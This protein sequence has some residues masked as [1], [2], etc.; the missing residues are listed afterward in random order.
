[1]SRSIQMASSL[2][3]VTRLA[4]IV[5]GCIAL[6]ALVSGC[7]TTQDS[8]YF[9]YGVGTNLYSEDI[10]Q[11]TQLQDLYFTELCRQSLPVVSTKDIDCT[12]VRMSAPDWTL[13]VQAG[14]NDVDRRCDS[15]LAWLDD[16]R[17][18]NGAVLKEL[19]DVTVASQAIMRVAGVSANPITLAGLAFGLASDTFTNINS[20]LLTEIDKTTVQTLVLKR[21]D[22]FRLDIAG[23]PIPDRPTA[24]HALRLYLTICTPFAIETEINST[25]TVFQTAGVAG[26]ARTDP[27]VDPRTIAPLLI[28]DIR[29]PLPE[30]GFKPP[31]GKTAAQIL[32]ERLRDTLCMV[33]TGKTRDQSVKDFLV[34]RGLMLG[35]QSLANVKIPKEN[36]LLQHAAASIPDCKK[37]GFRNAYEVGRFGVTSENSKAQ[38][39]VNIDDLQDGLRSKLKL[40]DADLT[41][42]QLDGPTRTAI[43]SF[44]DKNNLVPGDQ[45]DDALITALNK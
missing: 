35:S 25:I 29:K 42:H 43:K 30:G 7:D 20:R 6:A 3:R 45:V 8:Q 11:T 44:R 36:D 28:G 40:P 23:R 14:M 31:P 1:M 13:I 4:R 9:R 33:D 37:A 34:G 24:A 18:T 22:G 41:S 21:R 10:V 2:G 12:G 32:D 17:R 38:V 15:Y 26:L 19:G 39:A 27:L 16:R 5:A